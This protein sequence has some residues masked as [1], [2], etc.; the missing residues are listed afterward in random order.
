M[1]AES[2]PDDPTGLVAWL[3]LQQAARVL[4]ERTEER[5]R[6]VTNLSWSEFELLWRL[7]LAAHGPLQMSEIATRLL[8]SPSG[9]TRI[10]DRLERAGL[11][12][13]ETPAENRRVV[14]VSL[15][16][17]GRDVVARAEMAMREVLAE[18]FS[19]ALSNE[20][21]QALRGILG[22]LL[23]HNGAWYADRCEPSTHQ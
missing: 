6:Q 21:A 2:V 12:Q 16:A 11:I 17:S 15:T 9:S 19:A 3:N 18:S 4:H 10:V 5:L 20:D 1:A 7:R 22:N 14:L 23:R 8:T 13:R